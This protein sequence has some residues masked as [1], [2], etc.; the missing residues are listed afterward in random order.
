MQCFYCGALADVT[1]ILLD[2]TATMLL[3]QHVCKSLAVEITPTKWILGH[4]HL[5][6]PVIWL[7]NFTLYKAHLMA[8]EWLTFNINSLLHDTF[9]SYSALF[10]QLSIG[11]LL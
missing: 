2:C 7:T 5:V 9:V 11:D 4:S 1:H 8:T 10:P 6:N 3:H